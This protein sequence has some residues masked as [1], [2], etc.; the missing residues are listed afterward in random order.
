MCVWSVCM[1]HTYL[2]GKLEKK[3]FDFKN[4]ESNMNYT[5]CFFWQLLISRAILGGDEV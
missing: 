5:L 4:S 2:F 1:Q 3:C